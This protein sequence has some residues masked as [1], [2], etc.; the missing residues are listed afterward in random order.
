MEAIVNAS[1]A[2]TFAHQVRG[3]SPLRADSSDLI[4]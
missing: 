4:A 3:Q 2:L 1:V